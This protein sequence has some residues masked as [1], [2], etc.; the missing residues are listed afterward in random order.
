MFCPTVFIQLVVVVKTLAAEAT[1]RMAS[2]T[3][4]VQRS[5]LVVAV[6][7]VFLQL[8]ICEELV[9]V[10]E[11]FLVTRAEV[12]HLLMVNGAHMSVEVWPAKTCKIARRIWTVITEQQNRVP[13]NVLVGIANPDVAVSARG[14][15]VCVLFV[16]LCGVVGE[17]HERRW[18]LRGG[19]V[20]ITNT[21]SV[22]SRGK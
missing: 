5:W 2:E 9:L 14:I 12:T 19:D 4:L 22:A 10:G 1:E 7:H 3:C 8:L 13:D 11:D 16:A 20:S 21:P 17:D 15:G 18:G 6:A